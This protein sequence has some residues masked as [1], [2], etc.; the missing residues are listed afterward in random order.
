LLKIAIYYAGCSI[1]QTGAINMSVEHKRVKKTNILEW[2]DARQSKGLYYFTRKEAFNELEP[3]RKVFDQAIF[4][5]SERSRIV[6]VYRGFY[7]IIPLEYRSW[8]VLPADW[9][10]ADLMAYLKQ[11]YYAGLLT[12]ADYHGASHQ[13]PQVFHV[14]TNKLVRGITC[15]RVRIKFFFKKNIEVTPVEK[16]NT[17][18]GYL[19]IST[20]EATSLDL[21]RYQARAGG[22]SHALT[23]LQELGEKINPDSLVKAAKADGCVSYA[24]RLGWLMGKTKYAVNALKLAKWIE[25]KNPVFIRLDPRLPMKQSEKDMRWR[26]WINT[27][28]EGDLP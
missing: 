18:T 27:K 14:V 20:P 28:V 16:R 9:F 10:I 4:R 22:L 2:I 8:G 7:L 12:A 15:K 5:L 25:G 3:D 13:K 21:M 17:Q 24:Q 11:P 6:S 1:S 23:V 19:N 26:L